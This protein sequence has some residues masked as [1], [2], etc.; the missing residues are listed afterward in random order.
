MSKNARQHGELEQAVLQ[1]L[2]QSRAAGIPWLSSQQVLEQLAEG[3]KLALTTV[4]TVLSRLGDKNLVTRQQGEGRSLLFSS[5]TS[6]E[7]YDAAA[8]LKVVEASNNPALAFSYFAKQLSSKD[9][10]L[11]RQT[12]EGPGI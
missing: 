9:L 7:E 11:L 4:L 12:L 6:Q 5:S 3:P 8:L 10:E 2:W 1:V